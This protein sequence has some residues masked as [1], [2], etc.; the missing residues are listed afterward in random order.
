MLPMLAT[1]GGAIL[2]AGV[3]PVVAFFLL[4]GVV[5]LVRGRGVTP[6]LI[7]VG[8]VVALAVVGLML[9]QGGLAGLEGN[10]AYEITRIGAEG[11]AKMFVGW[12]LA[13]GAIAFLARMLKLATRRKS[14]A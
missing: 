8:M 1:H 5:A 10:P 6:L 13:L 2:V 3:L 9:W 4:D 7:A 14:R 12:G 11:N